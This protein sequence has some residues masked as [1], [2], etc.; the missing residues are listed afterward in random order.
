MKRWLLLLCGGLLAAQE[1]APFAEEG[2]RWWMPTGLLRAETEH[3]DLGPGKEPIHRQRARLH[4]RWEIGEGPFQLLLGSVHSLSSTSNQKDIPWFENLRSNGS[5]LDL[6]AV[7][8]Q[9]FREGG[10]GELSGGLIENPL[11]VGESLWDPQLRVIGGSG[12]LLWR[13]ESVEELGLRAVAGDVRLIDGGRVKLSAGQAVFRLNTGAVR[14][15]AHAGEWRLEPRQE[16]AWKFLRQNPGTS[17][18]TYGVYG[19]SSTTVA[20]YP[21]TSFDFRVWGFGLDSQGPLPFEIKAQRHT[22]THLSDRGEE[23]QVWIGSPRRAWWPQAGWIRQRLDDTGAL[24]SVNGDQW[25]F[26][27]N[28]DGNLYVLALN[29]PRRWRLEGRHMDQVRRGTTTK[30]TRESL[31]LIA[32]F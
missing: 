10:G 32:R 15:T 23:L 18:T 22:H 17:I 12:R 5:G 6:A 8:V 7:K 14:W 28:A 30:I 3:F 9:G 29:L 19:S 1:A 11:I 24:A 26:H 25:W 16:D 20:A 21:S 31:A 13:N 2:S 27:A 4:L